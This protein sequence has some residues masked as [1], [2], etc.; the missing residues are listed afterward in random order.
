[1]YGSIV[2]I[3]RNVYA[4]EAVQ[5]RLSKNPYYERPYNVK[6]VIKLAGS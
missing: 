6:G 1:M 3:C 4:V 2:S 5:V